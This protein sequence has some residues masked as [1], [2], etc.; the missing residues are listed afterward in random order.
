[1]ELTKLYDVE[2][3]AFFITQKLVS[4]SLVVCTFNDGSCEI[5]WSLN[6]NEEQPKGSKGCRRRVSC[7]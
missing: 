6:V 1:M 7:E 4:L 3:L 5:V 2:T